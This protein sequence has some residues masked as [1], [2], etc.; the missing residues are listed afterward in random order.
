MKANT[1]YSDVM[2]ICITTCLYFDFHTVR[3]PDFL[4][5]LASTKRSPFP[6]QLIVISSNVTILY[7]P[8]REKTNNVVSE[9]V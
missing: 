4:F 3:F 1:T 2:E 5:V 7:E 6:N 9:Q 8:V